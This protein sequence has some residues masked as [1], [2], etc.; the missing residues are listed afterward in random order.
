[1]AKTVRELQK[2]LGQ[3]AKDDPQT[4]IRQMEEYGSEHLGREVWPFGCGQNL[5]PE[6]EAALCVA[7]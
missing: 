6:A 3:A 5:L 1:M 2:V 7:V 4:A